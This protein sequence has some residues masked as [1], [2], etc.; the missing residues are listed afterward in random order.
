MKKVYI[1]I[2]IY[3]ALVLACARA[4]ARAIESVFNDAIGPHSAD[5][6]PIYGRHF[7]VQPLLYGAIKICTR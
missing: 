3:I 7:G 1:Y 6:A 4:R 2:A 5:A